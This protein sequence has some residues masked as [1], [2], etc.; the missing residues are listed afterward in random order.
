M[1]KDWLS[2]LKQNKTKQFS[3]ICLWGGEGAMGV[4]WLLSVEQCDI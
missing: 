1:N 4:M 2:S 3:S